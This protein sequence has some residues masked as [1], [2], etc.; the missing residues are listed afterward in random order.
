LAIVLMISATISMTD[1][2]ERRI[3]KNTPSVVAPV[4]EPEPEAIEEP[5][6]EPEFKPI[7]E[8]VVEPESE[9][10][11]ELKVAE[12]VPEQPVDEKQ[13]FLDMLER[14]PEYLEEVISLVNES[15]EKPVEWIDLPKN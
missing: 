10:E 12:P 13:K 6:A 2:A 8:S 15:S 9:P 7:E 3:A 14:H 5:G 1:W 11:P 4:V